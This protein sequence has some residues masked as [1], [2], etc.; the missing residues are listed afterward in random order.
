VL[1]LLILEA[2]GASKG[3]TEVD[4]DPDVDLS[5][6]YALGSMSL[7]NA[8]RKG[9]WFLMFYAPWCSH[10]KRLK[11]V[12][13]ALSHSE[14]VQL[15][16]GMRLGMIDCTEHKNLCGIHGVK[17]YPN[18]RYVVNNEMYEYKGIRE[19]P[20]WKA[21]AKRVLVPEI[22]R[23]KNPEE[24]NAFVAPKAPGENVVNFVWHTSGPLKDQA[25]QLDLHFKTAGFNNIGF[26][27]YE[28]TEAF[29][30]VAV[31]ADC[32]GAAAEAGHC[33]VGTEALVA[34]NELLHNVYTGASDAKDMTEWVE[35]N[36]FLQVEEL[37]NTK[38]FALGSL[39]KRMAIL[40]Y[41]KV[42]DGEGF[43]TTSTLG[44]SEMQQAA[45]SPL[46]K[47]F[48]FGRLDGTKWSPWVEGFDIKPE[49]YPF[50]FVFDSKLEIFHRNYSHSGL[51]KAAIEKEDTNTG[52]NLI[53]DYLTAVLEGTEPEFGLGMKGKMNKFAKSYLPFLIGFNEETMLLAFA[54]P[55]VVLFA[56]G[57]IMFI[58]WQ[59]GDDEETPASRNKTE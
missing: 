47:S 33:V 30:E 12:Y 41:E 22:P 48:V 21:F 1:L 2:D 35:T 24:F 6:T 20:A 19:L 45:K 7:P 29:E 42:L 49:Q 32:G 59:V 9:N 55:V 46:R 14:E 11:P 25:L 8:I 51:L 44:L 17:G 58:G 57:V 36:R 3:P 5:K 50:L 53:V 39:G 13:A 38:F 43:A 37:D 56:C 28:N 10:C 4:D 40:V 15:G 34:Y 31:T 26:A 16:D 18:F 27:I 52:A 23:L 54:M